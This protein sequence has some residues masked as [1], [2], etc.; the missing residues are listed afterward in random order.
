MN[1]QSH[2]ARLFLSSCR[3]GANEFKTADKEL[4]GGGLRRAG[5]LLADAQKS[6]IRLVMVV[7]FHQIT[8]EIP[9]ALKNEM[10]CDSTSRSLLLSA[11]G[12]S[13]RSCCWSSGHFITGPHWWEQ[14][15]LSC[16]NQRSRLRVSVADMQRGPSVTALKG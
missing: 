13:E 12:S 16:L 6:F 2:L 3:E 7:Q 1:C 11:L 5:F 15:A 8:A 4:G 9:S 14:R 10:K